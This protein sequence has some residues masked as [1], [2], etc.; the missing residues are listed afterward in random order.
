M[1]LDRYLLYGWIVSSNTHMVSF[2]GSTAH[3]DESVC[4]VS[5][6]RIISFTKVD[7]ADVTCKSPYPAI[8]LPPPF[9]SAD[10]IFLGNFVGVSIW[11]AVEPIVGI[12]GAVSTTVKFYVPE[13][14]MP[15]FLLVFRSRPH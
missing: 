3:S 5:I 2:T 12:L 15:E 7:P 4:V 9:F 6:I 10:A 8:F 1:H 13:L 14:Q 11:S